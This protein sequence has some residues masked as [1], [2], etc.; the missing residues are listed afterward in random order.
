MAPI[1]ILY[2][3]TRYILSSA[4]AGKTRDVRD[5]PREI[6]TGRRLQLHYRFVVNVV[7]ILSAPFSLSV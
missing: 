7:F 3:Y 5:F 4:A 6:V 2:I 1:T